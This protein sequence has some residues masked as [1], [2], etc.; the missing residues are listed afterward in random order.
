MLTRPPPGS[1]W[2]GGGM[3]TKGNAEILPARAEGASVLPGPQE[4]AECFLSCLRTREG[5]GSLPL[6]QRHQ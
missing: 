6:R 4:C 1:I 5:L 3:T 2:P